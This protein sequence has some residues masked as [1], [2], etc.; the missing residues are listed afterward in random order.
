LAGFIAPILRPIVTSVFRAW[1]VGKEIEREYAGRM[2]LPLRLVFPLSITTLVLAGCSGSGDGDTEGDPPMPVPYPDR[3]VVTADWLN[4]SLTVFDHARLVAGDTVEEARWATIDLAE[5]A[6]G[7]LEVELTPDGQTAV[8]AVGPGFFVGVGELFLGNLDI[9]PG[10]TLLVVDLP[11]RAVRA[12]IAT[13]HVPMGIAIAP[14]GTEA[15]VAGFGEQDAPGNTIVRVDLAQGAVLEEVL[16]PGRPEQIALSADG[17]LGIVSVDGEGSIRTFD[18]AGVADSLSEPVLTSGDP[19]GVA[20][21]EGTA[22]GLVANSLDPFGYSTIDVSSPLAPA[23]IETVTLDFDLPFAASRIPG[24]KHGLLGGAAG[25]PA[26]LVR[27]DCGATPA[28]IVDTI[29]LANKQGGFALGAA[30]DSDGRFAFVAVPGDDSLQ[31]V[32]L[33]SKAVRSLKWLTEAGPT[34]AAVAP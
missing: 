31:V 2:L 26:Q 3:V 33:E 9:P 13:T 18:P 7:P 17:S 22:V 8:V 20:L 5:H 14:G 21:I 15:F 29:T 30:V 25:S 12:E 19:S 28:A 23:L 32:D 16:V 11:G 34:Y 10:G 6:P 1:H 4:R 27:I 24:T